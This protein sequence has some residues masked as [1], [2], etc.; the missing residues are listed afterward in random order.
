MRQIPYAKWP[1]EMLNYLSGV[2]HNVVRAS[3][4]FHEEQTAGFVDVSEL[5]LLYCKPCS[6]IRNYNEMRRIV[7]RI[8]SLNPQYELYFRG[9]GSIHKRGGGK[10]F[11]H[12]VLPSLWRNRSEAQR[13]VEILQECSNAMLKQYAEFPGRDEATLRVLMESRPAVWALLQHYELC[14][15]PL[16]DLTR[17]LQIACSFALQYGRANGGPGYV[18]VFGLPFQQEK[19]TTSQSESVLCMSLLGITPSNADR[20]LVQD[21]YLACDQNWWRCAD[22]SMLVD[23]AARDWDM[24]VRILAVLEIADTPGDDRSFWAQSSLSPLSE[25]DLY[26]TADAFYS[27]FLQQNKF[28]DFAR[29]S[30]ESREFPAYCNRKI[31]EL[32][33]RK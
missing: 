7:A 2:T 20:P 18:Y 32:G 24:A 22:E 33:V 23:A 9:Q 12:S 11:G 1:P 19:M 21:G 14:A 3:H 25:E 17:T 29:Q 26:P 27:D 30:H 13:R 28:Y 16:V 6:P 8:A 31:D 10:G 15:T 4:A 5:D